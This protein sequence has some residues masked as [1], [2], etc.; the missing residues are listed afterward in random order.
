MSFEPTYLPPSDD[1]VLK[2]I[3]PPRL[4]VSNSFR[5]GHD[6]LHYL[7]SDPTLLFLCLDLWRVESEEEASS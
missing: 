4:V 6:H 2:P 7:G 5:R 3:S 1:C